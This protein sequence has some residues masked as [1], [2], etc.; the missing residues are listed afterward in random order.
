MTKEKMDEA[1]AI[2][3]E[4]LFKLSSTIQTDSMYLF[5]GN[6]QIKLFKTPEEII[7]VL[8]NVRLGLYKQRKEAMLHY[9]RYRLA[10][11]SNILAF[12]MVRGG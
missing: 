1:E 10:I 7:E 12:I 2:G 6:G 11:C 4:E 8:Y 3:F 9:L 5:D